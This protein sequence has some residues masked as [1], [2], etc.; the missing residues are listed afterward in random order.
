MQEIKGTDGRPDTPIPRKAKEQFREMPYA[1][2]KMSN[3]L[4]C[5]R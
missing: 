5:S 3:M 1:M 4:A 2:P